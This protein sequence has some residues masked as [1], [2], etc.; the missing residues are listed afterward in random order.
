MFL[1]SQ[2]GCTAF[3]TQGA[4]GFSCSDLAFI[5]PVNANHRVISDDKQSNLF[6]YRKFSDQIWAVPFEVLTPKKTPPR[7]LSS[8]APHNLKPLVAAPVTARRRQLCLGST[9]ET[10]DIGRGFQWLRF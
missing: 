7:S 1:L 6:C 4:W 5:S 10:K 9:Q 2:G 8:L 3:C